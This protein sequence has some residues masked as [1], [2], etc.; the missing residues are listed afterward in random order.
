MNWYWIGA[1]YLGCGV[2]VFLGLMEEA[3]R[4]LRQVERHRS[5]YELSCYVRQELGA[6]GWQ[7]LFWPITVAALICT[8][9]PKW[10]MAAYMRRARS[11]RSEEDTPS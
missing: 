2:G 3:A 9:P 5:D 6:A 4:K 1:T 8:K 7:S 10:L 11:T